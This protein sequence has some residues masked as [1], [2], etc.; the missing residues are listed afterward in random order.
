MSAPA[1]RPLVLML[2]GPTA[3]GKSAA[4]LRLAGELDGEIVTVD[5]MQVYRGMDIGS[6]K[7]S[8]AERKFIPHHLIDVA[9][10]GMQPFP[11]QFVR[12]PGKLAHE[13]QRIAGRILHAISL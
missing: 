7:P 9:E 4:A 13:V 11:G 8:L 10:C 5:S 2:A 3:T 6:A 1:E 12:R